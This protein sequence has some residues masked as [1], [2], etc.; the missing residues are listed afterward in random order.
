[1]GQFGDLEFVVFNTVVR[2]G[3]FEKV[4]FKKRYNGVHKSPTYIWEKNILG[5]GNRVNKRVSNVSGKLEE[6]QRSPVK[7]DQ[8]EQGGE[9]MG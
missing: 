6:L 3:F 2:E 9:N 4:R 7:L 8:S 5:R 1:M